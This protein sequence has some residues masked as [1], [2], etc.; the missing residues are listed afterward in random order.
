VTAPPTSG[1]SRLNNRYQINALIGNGGMASV[2]EAHDEFLDRDVALKLFD[3]PAA[4][5]DDVAKQEQEVQIL[6]RLNHHALV[7]LIDAGVVPGPDP[8]ESRRFLVMELVRGSTLKQMIAHKS[9][10]GRDIGHIGA[11]LAEALKY[12]HHNGVIHRDIKPGNVLMVDYLDDSSERPRAKLADFGIAR[13][14]GC[15]EEPRPVAATTGTAAYL[16]PEQALGE[17]VGPASDVYSLGL[18]L[19][20]CFTR[21]TAF[22]GT[23][24]ESALA[25][26]ERDPVIPRTLPP[27]WYEIL[28]AMTERQ[29]DARPGIDE[30]I[31]TL[32]QLALQGR[33][34]HSVETAP[35]STSEVARMQAVERYDILDTP[36]DGAFDRITGLAARLF[37]APIAIVSIVDHDRI[38][39]KSRRG[40]DVDQ[41]QRLG[42]LSTSAI[43]HDEP[44]VVTDA[45]TDPAAMTSKAVAGEMGIRFYV[46]VPL[47]TAD[48][49]NLG[50]LCVLDYEARPAV[51]EEEMRNLEDLAA[52]VMSELEL[53]LATRRA[54]ESPQ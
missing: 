16:S 47:Q 26:L 12:I 22:P 41:V 52:M 14:A 9:L 44:W 31:K 46:A 23:V 51:T 20:E 35:L 4:V 6:A 40:V 42:S 25:R 10:P 38:W 45:R 36:P 19:L 28:R 1:Y 27:G 7:T 37:D 39:F 33:S 8:S 3:A 5:L 2:Y 17:V 50:T 34:R 53:R 43:L 21:T 54:L 11:D 18:L 32:Q 49:H 30:V 15:D 29:A 24:L 13:L 48:G